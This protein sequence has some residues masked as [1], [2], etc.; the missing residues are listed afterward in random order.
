MRRFV[1]ICNLSGTGLAAATWPVYRLV[2]TENWNSL[3]QDD[4][5]A[6]TVNS[7]KNRLEIKRKRQ[8]DFFKG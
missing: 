4:I 3:S 8:M 7:F 6:A 5:E 1:I 2:L